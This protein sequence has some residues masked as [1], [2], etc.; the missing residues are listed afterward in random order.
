M[1]LP[2][3]HWDHLKSV[4]VYPWTQNRHENRLLAKRTHDRRPT[5]HSCI[6]DS[7]LLASPPGPLAEASPHLNLLAIQEHFPYDPYCLIRFVKIG[8]VRL[9]S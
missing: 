4:L 3:H 6:S 8:I 9:L 2:P 7:Q 5:P 1:W